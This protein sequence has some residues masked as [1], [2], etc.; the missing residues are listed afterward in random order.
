VAIE[1]WRRGAYLVSTD[2][3][4]LDFKAAH[5]YLSKSYWGKGR[6]LAR[7]KKGM[8]NSVC[9]GLYRGREQVGLARVITD[10]ATFAYLCDVY[11]RPDL[12]GGGLG[13]WLMAC[14]LKSGEFKDVKRWLLA[15]KDA[16]GLYR[17]F[18]FEVDKRK[19]RWMRLR[20]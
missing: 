17:P 1:R 16:H 7:L 12:Q 9:F 4:K 18:G 3:K 10:F 20:R 2:P 6:P 13:K 14:V 11:V 8:Q 19:N 5:A 15:T